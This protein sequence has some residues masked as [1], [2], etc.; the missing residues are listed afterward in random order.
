MPHPVIDFEFVLDK[1][2]LEF[3]Q[4]DKEI[5]AGVAVIGDAAEYALVWE[6]GNT[7]Q[8]KP[9]PKTVLGTS[10]DGT[11]IWLSSQAPF[12]YIRINEGKYWEIAK[13]VLGEVR[14]TQTNA[15]AMTKELERAAW[16]MSTMMAEVVK[17]SAPV[18]KGTLQRGITPV[19]PGDSILD[20]ELSGSEAH[21]G[22]LV[23]EENE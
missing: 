12:G 3:E 16:K 18:D 1:F 4:H 21:Y 6:W 22:T 19:K 8:T 5:F 10:P 9:G 23:L 13:Q 20:Q 17:M 2:M 11:M 15:V 7:R 14:F